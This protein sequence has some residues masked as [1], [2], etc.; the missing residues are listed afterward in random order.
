MDAS[1]HALADPPVLVSSRLR[2]RPVHADDT[3]TLRSI[4][5]T[6][7]VA[8]WWHEPDDDFPFDHE[9]GTS[10]WTVEIAHAPA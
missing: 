7:A 9:D 6:P 10:R 3:T 5:A 1:L 4:L 2:L 8:A